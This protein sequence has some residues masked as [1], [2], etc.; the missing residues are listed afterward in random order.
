MLS[1]VRAGPLGPASRGEADHVE[2]VLTTSS[3]EPAGTSR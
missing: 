1:R 2:I 3:G